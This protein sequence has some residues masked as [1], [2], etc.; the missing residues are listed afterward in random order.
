MHHRARRQALKE[1]AKAKRL[2]R[3]K[4]RSKANNKAFPKQLVEEDVVVAAKRESEPRKKLKQRRGVKRPRVPAAF[5]EADAGIAKEEAEIARL[6]KLLGVK[7]KRSGSQKAKLRSELAEID[8]FG[9]DLMDF[10]DAFDAGKGG[11]FEGAASAEGG[12]D[13]DEDDDE[14]VLEHPLNDL[15]TDEEEEEGEEEEE[16][17]DENSDDGD[18]EED[19]D[20][21]AQR[22]PTYRPSE[23]E[24]IY[25]RRI[26]AAVD[27]D[28]G[29]TYAPPHLRKQRLLAGVSETNGSK[30][31]DLARRL[32]G[33]LNR[34]TEDSLEPVSRALAALYSSFSTSAVNDAL[35]SATL[36][37]CVHPRQIMI[38]LIP[39]YA[40]LLASLHLNRGA[41]VGGPTLERI[42][43]ELTSALDQ[44]EEGRA[45][46]TNLSLLLGHLYVLGVTHHGL[47]TDVIG[48]LAQR[49]SSVDLEI[50]PP[51]LR[52]CAKSLRSDDSAAWKETIEACQKSCERAQAADR[53]MAE[54]ESSSSS[55]RARLLLDC[56]SDMKKKGR[57]SEADG[58]E[59]VQRLRKWLGRVRAAAPGGGTASLRVSWSD[60]S[61]IEQRG[62]WWL[63]GAAW[64]GSEGLQFG[65]AAPAKAM[66]GKNENPEP[67]GS[68]GEEDAELETLAYR[69]RMNTS[70]RKL[71]FCALM[72]AADLEDAYDRLVR[73]NLR[74]NA[75]RDIVRVIMDC[76]AQEKTYNPF[77]AFVGGRFCEV[78]VSA[79]NSKSPFPQNA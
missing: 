46:A 57:R 10:L 51:L 79:Q 50:L 47:I 76:C 17:E 19:E 9:E 59:R 69:Q 58:Q 20:L 33:Q 24:D 68:D 65:S 45:R 72:G 13:E 2:E 70:S 77:Y 31:R 39:L 52:L 8:G 6:E 15:P 61:S 49:G 66:A 44:E 32:N 29:G 7:G 30:A 1:A 37:V 12:G 35:L 74:G 4:A 62:R 54:G 36:Q 26:G 16:E 23:G 3:A 71:I 60:L 41:E 55:T 67:R 56:I 53:D 25:G 34:L 63:V 40:G 42:G 64:T 21:D 73:L 43:Q 11:K 75:D 22:G 78:E 38:A 18:E 48:V 5:A 27:G 14:G 28:S